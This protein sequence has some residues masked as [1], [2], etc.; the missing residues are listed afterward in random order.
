MNNNTKA[1]LKTAELL[2]NN[3]LQKGMW[4]LSFHLSPPLGW[5][6]DPNGLCEYEGI[7]HIFFQYSPFDTCPGMNYWGH[8]TTSDFVNFKYHK[9]ALC[10]DETIDCHGVYSG[11]ALVEKGKMTLFYT[12]NVKH[13]D[14]PSYDY[15]TAGREHN[16]I[17]VESKTGFDFE[18][19]NLLLKNSDYPKSMSCHVRD[20]KVWREG[21][22]Y[23]MV[24][25]AR[26]LDNKGCVLVYRS[27]DK[28]LWSYLNTIET[29]EPFG[30]MW[31]CPDYFEINNIRFLS[32]SPQGLK[33]DG[34][35]YNNVYQ[36]GYFNLYGNLDGE[37]KVENFK[38][39]DHGFDFYAPQ[40][41]VDS[42]GRRILIAWMGLP[43]ID[44]ENP[45]TENGW[46]HCLTYPRELSISSTSKLCQ[47]PIEEI[48]GLYTNTT[49]CE[50]LSKGTASPHFIAADIKIDVEEGE[51]FLISIKAGAIIKYKNNVFTLSFDKSGEGRT[52]RQA[53]I[54]HIENIRILC[55]TSSLEIFIN[56]GEDVFT[57]RFYPSNIYGDLNILGIS[58]KMTV[59]HLKSFNI[60]NYN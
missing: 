35:K 3:K 52:S 48:K 15:T 4:N 41:Y 6:N 26:T 21:S 38:E 23:Y 50:V 59:N 14:N 22:I 37:V 56:D 58:G 44:Y 53:F 10:C 28:R 39:Y 57:S 27:L 2:E 12:G 34:F 36:S 51:D 1:L 13:F 32:V 8:F 42:K 31:E 60:E 25:G 46:V 54:E 43:D 11:S 30:Y 49:E 33:P 40:T 17:S 20:P 29:S 7:H 24:L 45:T 47:N 16:T 55:D 18:Q 19:K 5:M 9:P